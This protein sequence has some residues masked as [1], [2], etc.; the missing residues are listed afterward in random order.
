MKVVIVIPLAL[1][2]LGLVVGCDTAPKSNYDLV[3]LVNAT[4]LVT[5][6]GQPL[7][8]AVI[9]FEADDGQFSYAKTDSSGRYVLQFDTVKRGVTP[10]KKTVRISTTRK[11]LGL[12]AEE[13]SA[14][15]GEGTEEAGAKPTNGAE[16]VPAKFNRQSE[17]KVEVTE[18]QTQ[19]DFDLKS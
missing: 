14:P 17:L 11:I 19:Y 18:E 4:G 9:T 6:D 3:G 8:E 16:K 2:V 10:G 15:A 7:A 5:L 13:E 1:L 12:N